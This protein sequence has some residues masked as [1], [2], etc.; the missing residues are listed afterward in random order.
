MPLL[1]SFGLL[2][3][4]NY[5]HAASNDALNPSKEGEPL[6]ID[7]G[8]MINF[9]TLIVFFYLLFVQLA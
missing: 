1:W 4:R 3:T 5:R 8:Y 7:C 9:V 6:A 2:W